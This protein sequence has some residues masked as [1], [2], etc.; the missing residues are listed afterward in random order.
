MYHNF[1]SSLGAISF[2]SV[3]SFCLMPMLAS[4]F[5]QFFLKGCDSSSQL[6]KLNGFLGKLDD[7]LRCPSA[8]RFLV[9]VQELY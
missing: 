1:S 2:S 3:S 5:V 9:A 6:L 7:V 8:D 4:P